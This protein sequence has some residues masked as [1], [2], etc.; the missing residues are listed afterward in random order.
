MSQNAPLT[1]DDLRVM[2]GTR[3]GVHDVACSVCGPK[4]RSSKN[5]VRAVLRIW[6]IDDRFAT[7]CCA[8]CGLKGEAYAERDAAR[9][10]DR[11]AFQRARTEAAARDRETA[12]I[13]LG[14]ARWI[15]RQRLA[16][17]GTIVEKYLREIRGYGGAFP[18]TLGYLPP[19]G[20]HGPAMVACYGTP[21]EPEPGRLAMQDDAVMGVQI[22][23]LTSDGR[24]AADDSKITV[25]KCLGQPIVVQAMNDLLGLAITEGAEDALSV[26]HATGLGAWAAGGA[27]RM[28]ALAAAVPAYADVISIV[29]DSDE[30]G[31]RNAGE[32]AVRLRARRL[33]A[34]IV[35]LDGT[36]RPAA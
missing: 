14:K 34:E 3:L 11:A 5:Q 2:T 31:R 23:K 21:I 27:S 19:R 36:A 26:A 35:A 18:A 8:R 15:W 20:L 13:Q 24:K 30:A 32:L 10:V 4:C 16:I 29:A 6:L 33:R 1:L 7:Y 17:P 22:T 28:P 12:A 25:G 9:H